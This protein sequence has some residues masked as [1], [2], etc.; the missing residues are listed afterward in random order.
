MKAADES[1]RGSSAFLENRLMCNGETKAFLDSLA[2]QVS[3]E[4]RL[5]ITVREPEGD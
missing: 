2:S 4:V 3:S 1:K 5:K